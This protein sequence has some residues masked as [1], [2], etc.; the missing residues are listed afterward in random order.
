MK[1]EA[2]KKLRTK[3]LKLTQK[4]LAGLLGIDA[5]TVSRWE[6]AEQR[7]RAVH[8]RQLDRLMKKGNR[9]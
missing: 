1:A 3:I 6:R 5:L 7:P 2:I 8:I 4:E 9:G